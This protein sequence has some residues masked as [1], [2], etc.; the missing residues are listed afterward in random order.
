MIVLS[1]RN[2]ACHFIIIA[3]QYYG[4]VPY[5]NFITGSIFDGEKKRPYKCTHVK[6]TFRTEISL[7]LFIIHARILYH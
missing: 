1:K 3:V 4:T 6:T 5:F 7:S 2:E